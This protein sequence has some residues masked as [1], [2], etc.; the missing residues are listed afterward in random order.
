AIPLPAVLIGGAERILDANTR[1]LHLLGQGI[2]GR[3]FI[4]AI[5]QPTVLDTIERCARDGEPRQTRYLTSD[6]AQDITYSVSCSRVDSEEGARV[7][8]CFEDVTHVELVGQMRRDF[9]ANVSHELRTPL[10]ALMGFIETLRGPAREDREASDRFLETMHVEAGRMER[11]VKDLLSLNRVEV[12]ERNRPTERLDLIALLISVVD[13]TTPILL[14]ADV[15]LRRVLPDTP[16]FVPGD[17]DQL[18]QVFTNLVE[19]AVKYGGPDGCITL[20][21]G[22]DDQHPALRVPSVTVSVID[23]GPGIEEIHI[24]RLTERFYRIDSHR[25]RQMGGTGLGLAIVKHIVNRHRGRLRIQSEPGVGSE[26]SVV[27][28]LDT[29]PPTG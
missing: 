13:A 9:V 29:L 8:V 18:R 2:V 22:M 26:F 1:A 5:R 20:R 15:T 24:P 11:L 19:N 28:P 3:H 16:V 14:G 7:L 23:E 25:S 4:T 27:L 10:T 17:A 12:Q 6:G 21:V